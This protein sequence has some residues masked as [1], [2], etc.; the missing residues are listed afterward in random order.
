MAEMTAVEQR[1]GRVNGE[2][3]GRRIVEST[4]PGRRSII[5]VSEPKTRNR[6]PDVGSA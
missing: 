3:R 1:M 2:S 4:G 5:K 6:L